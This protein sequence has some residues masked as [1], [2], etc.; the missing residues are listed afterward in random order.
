MTTPISRNHY[1]RRERKIDDLVFKDPF[2][3]PITPEPASKKRKTKTKTPLDQPEDLNATTPTPAI[4]PL[5]S[6]KPSSK[7]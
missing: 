3:K 4:R 6:S 5:K 7:V 2:S 1:Q